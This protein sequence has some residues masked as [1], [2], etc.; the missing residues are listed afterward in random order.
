MAT[1][2]R[3]PEIYTI[4]HSNFPISAFVALLQGAG[5]DVL[6]DVRS[7]PYSR[8][9]PQFNRQ[10]L[11]RAL[12]EHGIE[13]RFGG[14]ALGGR[15]TISV[16]A[17]LFRAKMAKIVAMAREGTTVALM[18]SE[19]NPAQCHRAGKLTAWIHREHPDV[20]TTHILEGGEVVDGRK[21]E[22]Q[23]EARV[24]W[25]EFQVDPPADAG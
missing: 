12:G 6:V 4:G 5:V 22:P 24:F 8:Y 3:R 23:I 9:N 11:A 7:L 15:T 25:H 18:C 20:L 2:K 19:R 1:K 17:A 14:K 13:Y 10:A 21:F 16:K